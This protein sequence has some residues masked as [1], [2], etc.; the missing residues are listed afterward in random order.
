MGGVSGRCRCPP[1]LAGQMFDPLA[2]PL[3][4]IPWFGL[5]GVALNRRCRP[6]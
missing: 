3:F 2:V 1:Y 5:A 4:A 6:I